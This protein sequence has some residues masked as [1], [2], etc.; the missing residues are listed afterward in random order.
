MKREAARLGGTRVRREVATRRHPIAT[1]GLIEVIR[2]L[3]EDVQGH[4]KMSP[5]G[6]ESREPVVGYSG[7]LE[8]R[9]DEW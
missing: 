9:P 3:G 8:N 7:L 6:S 1:A 2:G 4:E 5:G